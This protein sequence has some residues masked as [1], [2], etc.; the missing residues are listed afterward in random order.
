M[1]VLRQDRGAPCGRATRT[2]LRARRLPC[3][4]EGAGKASCPLHRLLEHS[5]GRAGP[6]FV[7]P[8]ADGGV[9]QQGEGDGDGTMSKQQHGLI[10]VRFNIALW[11]SYKCVQ[12]DELAM[13]E[14]APCPESTRCPFYPGR[15]AA[16]GGGGTGT[17]PPLS[18]GTRLLI[19]GWL[20]RATTPQLPVGG[21]SG[22]RMG[23]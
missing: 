23:R 19:R 14:Q 12:N 17:G 3:S 1:A 13:G 5:L 18:L 11:Q 8:C 10:S 2:Q 6:K 16:A 9:E 15:T 4:G 20:S 21:L 7:L 22:L